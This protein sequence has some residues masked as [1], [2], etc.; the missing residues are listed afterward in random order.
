MLTRTPSIWKLSDPEQQGV[1]PTIWAYVGVFG[2]IMPMMGKKMENETA[3]VLHKEPG[4]QELE[5]CWGNPPPTPSM[6]AT[7]STQLM[8][9]LEP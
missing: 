9:K 1:P 6:E 4:F 8:A 7:T 5:L 3:I 2:D